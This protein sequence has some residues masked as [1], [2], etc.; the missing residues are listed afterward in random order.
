MLPLE[1]TIKG[2]GP[3]LGVSISE[4]EFRLL[5]DS[6][7]FLIFG[8][9]GA[10]KT[11][12]FDAI[13]FALYGETSFPERKVEHLISHHIKPG[14]RAVPEVGFQPLLSEVKKP[15]FGLTEGFVQTSSQ[16]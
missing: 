8:E 2:F 16:R 14:D 13:L 10:G 7:L 1:L 12:L 11:T 5:Q 15:I 4:E 9:I 3:Y 6:R